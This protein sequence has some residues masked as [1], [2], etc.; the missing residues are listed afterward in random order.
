[1]LIGSANF[2]INSGTLKEAPRVERIPRTEVGIPKGSW[3]DWVNGN[4]K[5]PRDA[6]SMSFI[7][8]V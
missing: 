2:L 1:V 5:S 4:S 6:G 7:L 3:R 8:K